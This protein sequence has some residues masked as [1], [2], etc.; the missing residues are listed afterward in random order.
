MKRFFLGL[1][2]LAV[3]FMACQQSPTTIP[4]VNQPKAIGSL[5]LTFDSTSNQATARI[6]SGLQTQAVQTNTNVSFTAPTSL[7]VLSNA[8]KQYITAQFNVNN[9]LPSTSLT[10]LTLIAYQKTGNIGATAL[11]NVYNFAGSSVYPTNDPAGITFARG[12]KPS[13]TPS[14]LAPF[15]VNNAVSDVQFFTESEVT[16]LQTSANTAGELS[17]A[18]G[19]YLLPYGFVARNSSTSRTLAANT[20]NAGVVNIAIEI[21]SSNSSSATTGYRFTM[22]F[23]IFDA[24]VATRVSESLQEQGTSSGANTRKTGFAATQLFALGGSSLPASQISNRECVLRTAGSA[25]TPL[26]YLV[27]TFSFSSVAPSVNTNT[28]AN[29]ANVSVTT[30]QNMNAATTSSFVVRGGFTGLKAG[31]YSGTG[32]STLTF[33]PTTDFMPGELVTAQT[34]GLT[35]TSGQ[36]A[37]DQASRTWQYRANVAARGA[38]FATKTDYTTGSSPSSVVVADVNS[39]TKVDIIAANFGGASLSVLLGNGDGTFQAKTDHTTGS[40][41]SSVVVADVNSDTKLDI[42]TANLNSNSSSVLLGNG[43]GTFQAKTDYTTG[44]GPRSVVIAD[45]NN[46]TKLD[47][48]TANSGGNSSSVLLGNGDG[49]FQAKTDYTTGIRPYSVVV[50]DVNNDTKLDIITANFNSNSSSVLLGNGDGT[51][52]AKT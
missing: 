3:A 36:G 38:E 1:P 48:I 47:I 34:L 20:N 5:E 43:D 15:V 50:G 11:K 6:R 45:V 51:F 9:L 17:V 23:V 46:D 32:S 52:Q 25:G 21:P 18:G 27:N 42:I 31:V 29:N 22:T 7:S 2:L 19:E 24:P 4:S 35:N 26:D 39:D 12:V 41:P 40:G 8:S 14:G 30:N 13:N 28:A 44:S 16:A 33:D 10:D 37:C 49:T